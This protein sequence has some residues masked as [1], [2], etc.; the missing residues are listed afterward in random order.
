MTTLNFDSIP[1]NGAQVLTYTVTLVLNE[2]IAVAHRLELGARIA[3]LIEAAIM[4]G[5][6]IDYVLPEDNTV[7]TC[8]VSVALGYSGIVPPFLPGGADHES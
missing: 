7:N 3:E 4:N 8:Q 2:W 5:V 6:F 1:E